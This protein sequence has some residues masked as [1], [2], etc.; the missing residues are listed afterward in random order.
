[1]LLSSLD[2]AM[3]QG[4]RFMNSDELL[5]DFKQFIANGGP[6]PEDYQTFHALMDALA[7]CMQYS[8]VPQEKWHQLLSKCTFLSDPQSLIGHCRMRPYGYPGDFELLEKIDTFYHSPQHRKWD[9]YTHAHPIAVAMRNRKG[10]FKSLLKS[11]LP[12]GGALLDIGSNASRALYEYFTDNPQSRVV[13]TS[14]EMEEKAVSHARQLNKAWSNRIR[15]VPMNIFRFETTET[16]D[17]IWATHLFDYLYDAPFFTL[18]QKCMNWLKPDGE[19]VLCAFSDTR[20]N[21][22]SYWELFGNWHCQYRS[23][24]TLI[25]LAVAAGFARKNAVVEKDKGGLNQYLKLKR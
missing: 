10:Y 5:D 25:E 23:E 8:L 12:R 20:Q 17:L 18:L 1:M 19:M 24:E 13:V 16:Y 21:D 11:R 15:F 3:D 14:V 9:A 22:R 6:S 2:I 7:V 4:L